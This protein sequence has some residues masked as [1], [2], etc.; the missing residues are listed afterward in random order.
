MGEEKIRTSVAE[1]HRV[2]AAALG[3]AGCDG[4]NADAVAA[5]VAAAERDGCASHGVFRLAG[6]LAALRSGKVDGA[7]RPS[8]ARI[9]PGVLR[10]DARSGFAPLAIGAAREALAPLARE[11]GLAAAAV[12]DAHHFSALWAD[13]EPLAEAGLVAIAMTSYMPAVA[14]AGARVPFFG[15]NPMAF[16]WPRAGGTA[17][18]VDQASAAMARGEV[19]LA[20]REGRSLPP[21]T[22]I[23]AAGQPT[24]D[25]AAVLK[26]ALLPFGG[27]KGSGIALMVELLA[28]ALIGQSFSVE[29]AERDNKDGGPP[30]G[31]VFMLALDP[32]RFGDAE[33]WLD[34]GESFLARLAALDGVR[35]PG[36]RRAANRRRIAIEGVELPAKLWAEALEAAA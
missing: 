24:T 35:L 21:G 19:T 32:A 25:P 15:T 7:A 3:R 2:V 23:D 12:V 6:Y 9:A 30:S 36:D 27:H 16:A 33:G 5:V 18:V 34:H 10:V 20:A 26:G 1:V 14:P 17:L 4:A 8:V 29:A 22:G 13:V 28:G 31:G 11:Q